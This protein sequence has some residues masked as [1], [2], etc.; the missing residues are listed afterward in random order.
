VPNGDG[1]EYL[2]TLFFPDGTDTAAITR[3]MA[4][5]DEELHAV[6]RLCERPG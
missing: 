5:V 2:F 1:S 6:R 4:I 3:Q